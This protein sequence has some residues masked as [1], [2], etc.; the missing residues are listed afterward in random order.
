MTFLSAYLFHVTMDD[1]G[2]L[3]KEKEEGKRVSTNPSTLKTQKRK[4]KRNR[5]DNLG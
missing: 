3:D 1:T 4:S 5:K 2:T